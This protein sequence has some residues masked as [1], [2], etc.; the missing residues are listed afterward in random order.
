MSR[1]YLTAAKCINAV[2]KGVTFKSFCSSIKIGKTDYLLAAETLKY[3]GVLNDIMQL[4]GI[5][6]IELD[7]DPGLLQVM[8]Y[9]LLLGNKKKIQGGGQV[10]R[11]IMENRELL[12]SA[13]QQIMLINKTGSITDLLP[14]SVQDMA[15]VNKYIRVNHLK[16][17][18]VDA[19]N[20]IKEIYSHVCMDDLIPGLFVLPPSTTGL[21]EI[22]LV[23]LGYLI[24]QDKASCIPSQILMDEWNQG[25]VLD[26]C[27][28]PGNKTSHIASQLFRRCD[29][30]LNLKLP[31]IH[32]FEKDFS[33]YELLCKRMQQAGAEELVT[34]KNVDFLSID[35]KDYPHV[36]YILL[37]PSCSGSG[38]A[39]SINRSGDSNGVDSQSRVE[40]LSEFQKSAL[41][42]AMSCPTAEVVVYS[43]CSLNIEE[44]EQVVAHGLK[45]GESLGWSIHAPK[46]FQ[47]W[48]RRGVS[49]PDLSALQSSCL[50]RCL[51]EDGMNGFFVAL[52][53][54]NEASESMDAVQIEEEAPPAALPKQKYVRLMRRTDLWRPLTL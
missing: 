8:L 50:I 30:D 33:R 12:D 42:H 23:K 51:P 34:S 17:N 14:Q 15:K 6:A 13:L 54:R 39:K 40:R 38:I 9:E 41:V 21:G 2:N 32:A 44:N 45:E 29:E 37:D 27:S 26:A 22:E 28:A 5:N 4:S 31:S 53:K 19:L 49:C 35:W 52:F 11:K 46:R 43:T 25:D 16:L 47:T 7:V 3:Q 48:S 20:S 36:K 18:E 1:L 10:K 24:I